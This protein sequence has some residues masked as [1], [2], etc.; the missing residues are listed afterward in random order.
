MTK[1]HIIA[2]LALALSL[3]TSHPAIAQGQ[4]R[5]A[6]KA[7][8]LPHSVPDAVDKPYPG[9]TIALD[10][11]ASD[12]VHAAYRVTETIPVANGTKDLILELPQWIPGNHSP[13][14]TMSELVDVQFFAN[15]K[16]LKWWRDPVEVFAFHLELPA[17][18]AQV[19]AKFI[20]TSPLQPNEGR[21]TVTPDMLNLQWDRMSLYPAGYY[22]RQIKFK[23]TVKFPAGWGVATA[24]DGKEQSGDTVTWAPVE[25][26]TLVDSPVMA[27]VNFKRFDLGK[28][29]AMDVVADRPENLDVKPEHIGAYKALVDEAFLTYG[30]HHFDHYDILL[31]LSNKLGG[32]GLEHHR[33]SENSM[34]PKALT[35]WKDLDWARNVIPHEISHSWDG[36][37]RRPAKLWTPDYRQP[38]QDN[39]LWVYEGQNQ[40]WGLILA[41]RSGVQS[42]ENVLGQFASY[43]G[44]FTYE[45]G[46]E[47]RSVEDTTH[48]PIIANRRPKPFATLDRN[49]DYYTEGAL[50]WLE[51]DQIIREGTGGKKGLDD[52]AKVFFGIKNGDWGEVPYE[53]EDVVKALDTVYHYDWASFLHT[54]LQTPGQPVPLNG[55]EKGG[56]KL[57]WKDTPN[58]YDKGRI[59]AAK[60]AVS[61][62]YSLG[63]GISKD[64]TVTSTV[65]GSP[66]F[67]AG[68]VTGAKILGING[69]S[70][71]GDDMK[72]AVTAAKGTTTPITLVVERAGRVQTISIDYHDGLRYPWLEKTAKGEAGLDLLLAPRR[73]GAK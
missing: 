10:I 19:V 44:M 52:F 28:N 24:L 66:A 43:A 63:V 8:P 31:A 38:M 12:T 65:W 41:A 21:V 55:I 57:V 73:P 3:A 16:P 29:V 54:R 1:T 62:S 58:S 46:R 30:A 40:F 47:W 70:Y 49:E 6:P 37:F 51:A 22:V 20:N 5:S 34:Q 7:V 42:K 69:R 68:L 36:K 9:G 72:D 26:D 27:G 48:D 64:G 11:D 14:G 32:I 39:L 71:D 2:P 53:F 4:M 50:V 15:G 45:P 67:K 17:G 61:L 35:D 18:T 25:Y 59:D 60:G 23:P 33:S 56:Y 13:N